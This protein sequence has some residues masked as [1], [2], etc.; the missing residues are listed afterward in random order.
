MKPLNSFRVGLLEL[1]GKLDYVGA[2][3]ERIEGDA[4]ERSEAEIISE[5][6]QHLSALKLDD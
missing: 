2:Y 4:K 1:F 5:L 3:R 6:K